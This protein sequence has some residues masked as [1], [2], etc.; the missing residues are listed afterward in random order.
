MASH[1]S[2]T[3]EAAPAKLD[4]AEAMA[5]MTEILTRKSR[6]YW[7]DD[8][9]AEPK[10]Y[11][12][13][14][15]NYRT[16]V[17]INF[18]QGEV[19]VE[20]LDPQD[21]RHAII[22]TL[23]TPENPETVDLFTDKSIPLG[24]EPLLFGQVLD[25][26]GK[27]IRWQWDAKYFADYLMENQLQKTPSPYGVIYRVRISLVKDH[28]LKRQYQYAGIIRQ[29]GHYYNIDESLIYAIIHTESR[30]NP[31]AISNANAYG[32]M[33]IIPTSAGRDVFK[34]I[35][36]KTNELPNKDYLFKPQNNIEIGTAYLHILDSHYLKDIENPLSRKYSVISAYNGGAGNVLATFA[37]N[38]NKAITKIN[39]M[40]P[41]EVYQ[42][43]VSHH[44]RKE[45]RQYLKKVTLTQQA[46]YQLYATNDG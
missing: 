26:H 17:F 5:T 10:E 2:Q 45:S 8:K 28:T 36:N 9:H 13:Y 12:K 14:T 19:H 35:K 40:E 44:P 18:Q 42:A 7:G 21:L 3:T 29:Y 4:N 22:A 37:K 25:Q 27:P 16:R 33:Q 39:S 11:V 30:F 23:L 38:R 1:S 34:R 24:E 43:L 20:T 41:A 6:R 15:N 46:F 32:L 31:Y